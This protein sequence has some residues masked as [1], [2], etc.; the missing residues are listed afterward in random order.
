[1]HRKL[2]LAAYDVSEPRRLAQALKVVRMFATGG[3]KSA[4]ECWLTDSEREVLLAEMARVIDL[5]S[6]RFAVIPL[7]ARKPV[8]ALGIAVEPQDPNYFYFG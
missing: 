2:Y 6:D 1:M 5:A 8:T 3:Q 4:Y 7:D